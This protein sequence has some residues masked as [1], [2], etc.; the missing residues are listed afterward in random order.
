MFPTPLGRYQIEGA[1]MT[2]GLKTNMSIA[3]TFKEN[4]VRLG[5]EF[6]DV[7]PKQRIGSTD[8]ENVSHVVPA[9]H[10]YL[11]IGPA[12][13]V[14][15]STESANEEEKIRLSPLRCEFT[16]GAD[17]LGGSSKLV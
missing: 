2:R 9:I 6:G 5:W 8:M 16:L 7:D 11:S 12:G 17:A 1:P 15:H 3:R 4:L 14:G 13:L 10:P